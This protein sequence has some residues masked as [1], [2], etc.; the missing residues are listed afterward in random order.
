M[1]SMTAMTC[2]MRM[3][4]QVVLVK[5]NFVARKVVNAF[6]ETKLVT[7]ESI[8]EMVLTNPDVHIGGPG[9]KI[10]NRFE[11]KVYISKGRA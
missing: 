7:E 8:A 9:I 5:M 4:A 1:V 10:S 2:L 3:N 11:Q 6:Q